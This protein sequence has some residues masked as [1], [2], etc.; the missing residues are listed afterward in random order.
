LVDSL[1][2]FSFF[3]LSQTIIK[4][5]HTKPM[6]SGTMNIQNLLSGGA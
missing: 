4:I 5:R 2:L 3:Y 1:L 6:T